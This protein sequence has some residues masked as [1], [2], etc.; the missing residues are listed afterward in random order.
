VPN[1]DEIL[2]G[3]RDAVTVRRVFGEPYDQD[4]VTVTRC[5]GVR[6]RASPLEPLTE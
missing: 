1:V 4:G 2:E 3:A 5:L 6:P